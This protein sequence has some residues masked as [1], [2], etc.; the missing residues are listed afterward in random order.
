[1]K[2]STTSLE[3]KKILFVLIGISVPS[4]LKLAGNKLDMS[5]FVTLYLFLLTFWFLD[6]FTYYYQDKLR[7]LMDKRFNKLRIRNNEERSVSTTISDKRTDNNR[8]KRSLWNESIY[9]YPVLIGLNTIGCILHILG[10][11]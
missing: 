4:L 1:M 8:M 2:F 3:L 5:F 10:V 11:I 9:I 6:S 7:K